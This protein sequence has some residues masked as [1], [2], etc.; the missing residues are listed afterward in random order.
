MTFFFKGKLFSKT[1]IILNNINHTI[2][3]KK[4]VQLLIHHDQDKVIWF[5]ISSGWGPI[6][7][8]HSLIQT[9]EKEK[10]KSCFDL[11]CP[12]LLLVNRSAVSFLEDDLPQ[13]RGGEVLLLNREVAAAANTTLKV[14]EK[15]GS[16]SKWRGWG[17]G[18]CDWLDC[19]NDYRHG[20]TN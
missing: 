17:T 3:S 1:H 19:T 13:N 16:I 9:K 2:F 7:T 5:T 10:K 6:S 11:L 4:T 18:T 15:S 14:A 8:L 12:Q 20:Q